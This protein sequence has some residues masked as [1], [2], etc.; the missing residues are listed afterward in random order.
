M[1]RTQAGG[2]AVVAGAAQSHVETSPPVVVV[3]VASV[4]EDEG[5]IRKRKRALSFDYT[6]L[7]APWELPPFLDVASSGEEGE[8]E[9]EEG[10]SLVSERASP[11]P[12]HHSSDLRIPMSVQSPTPAQRPWPVA[13]HTPPINHPHQIVD[14]TF[15]L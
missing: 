2:T 11:A 13:A 15:E 3:V 4:E 9:E 7:P 6:H 14:P 5:M 12:H 1:S 8:E 10:S